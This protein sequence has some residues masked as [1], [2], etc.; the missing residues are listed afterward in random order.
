[1]NAVEYIEFQ[2]LIVPL[3]AALGLSIIVERILEF[4]QN[5]LEPLLHV[6]EGRQVPKILKVK[7][8]GNSGRSLKRSRIRKNN[9]S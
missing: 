9:K 2:T 3:A 4:A 5:I 1:M 8:Q 7:K 6:N